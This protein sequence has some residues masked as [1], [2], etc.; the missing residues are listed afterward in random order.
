VID[1]LD[2]RI[3]KLLES[4]ARQS[5][6]AIGRQL[7]IQ[8]SLITYRINRLHKQGI[9]RGYQYITDQAKLGCVSYGIL[10]RFQN[11][12]LESQEEIVRKLKTAH[13]FDWITL[14]A[15][16]WDAMAVV[17]TDDIALYNER[18]NEMFK[19]YGSRIR[20]FSFYIE[21]AGTISS[22]DYLYEPPYPAAVTYQRAGGKLPALEGLDLQIMKRLDQN[23]TVSLL[24]L[25]ALLNHAFDTIQSHFRLLQARN[26]LL[27]AVPVIDHE[28]LGYTNTI[29]FYKLKPSAKRMKEMLAFCLAHPQIVR[30][31]RCLGNFNLVLN[32]HSTDGR[33]L[34]TVVSEI[35][36]QFSDIIISY[37][38]VSTINT[39]M[40]DNNQIV[41]LALL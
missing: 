13:I 36:E 3:L 12:K 9:I 15:G 34:K 35:D 31:A 10:L 17:V 18:L 6:S 1:S 29:Y 38:S 4:D 19:L 39:A 32:I 27:R 7:G 23:A 30:Q 5:K 25:A 2:K 22:H 14:T 40:C 33:H 21:Y 41:S 26:I 24:R 8:K 11:A 16:A 28:V 37:E 20:D